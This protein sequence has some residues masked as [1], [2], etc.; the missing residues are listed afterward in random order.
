MFGE[1]KKQQYVKNRSSCQLLS[2]YVD[3]SLC[4]V[5]AS[6]TANIAQV[7]KEKWNSTKYQQIHHTVSRKAGVEK[8]TTSMKE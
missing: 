5:A 1:E 3:L 8:K 2:A 4:F 7:E 6:G